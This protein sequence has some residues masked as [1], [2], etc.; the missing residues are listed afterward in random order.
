MRYANVELQVLREDALTYRSDLLVLKYAQASYGVDRMAVRAAQIDLSTLPGIGENLLVEHPRG[1]ASTS[2]LLI[3]VEPISG[4]DYRTIRH[5]SRSALSEAAKLRPGPREISMTLHGVGFG[6]DET[7]AF[8]SEV[9]GVVE[10]IDAGSYPAEL[11]AVSFVERDKERARRMRR[12]LRSLIGDLSPYTAMGSPSARR[13]DFV[14]YDSAEKAHA[15]V[16]MPFDESFQDILHYG[17]SPPIRAAGLLC[18]RMDQISFTGN[19]IDRMRERI[20]SARLVV[21]DLSGANPNVYLEVGYAWG[22][23]VPC[24]LLCNRETDLK[25]DVQGHRCL[26]YGSI[27]E[28]EERLA[29][30]LKNLHG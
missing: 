26:L 23:G 16:A 27:R 5:F 25:F 8:E 11:H 21:A 24:V 10:A 13:V 7:E 15:F 12:C 9:A 20:E 17:I 1:V 28:L 19:I 18:E 2:L 30:E 3:G 6:L 29:A 4:L 14:G 22:R